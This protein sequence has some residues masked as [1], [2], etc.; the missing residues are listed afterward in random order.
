VRLAAA[1]TA[2]VAAAI[3]AGPVAAG[4]APGPGWTEVAADNGIFAAYADRASIRREGTVA[5]MRGMYDF[6]RG[7]FTPQGFPFHSTLVDREYDCSASRVRLLAYEDHAQRFGEG[8]IVGTARSLRRW[9][10]I[11]EGSLDAA[12]F[13]VACGAI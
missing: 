12:F 5:F 8:P 11:A 2:L 3:F 9:E 1:W 7:D 10:A 13:R 4:N 6:R